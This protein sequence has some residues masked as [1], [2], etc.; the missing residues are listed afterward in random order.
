M[1]TSGIKGTAMADKLVEQK[2]SETAFFAALRRALA[3]MEYGD[4][5]FGS[6]SLAMVFLPV[7][8]RF[9]MK[10]KKARESGNHQLARAF[11]G[12]NE[13]LMA[14]TAF[15]D[16]QFVEALGEETPQIVLLGAGYDSRAY[17]FARLNRGTRVFELDIAPTQNRKIKCLKA[18]RIDIPPQ[19]KF[20]PINFNLEALDG[21]LAK[22]GYRA[23]EK[24]LFTWE[25]VS[26]YLD[27]KSVEATLDFASQAPK[28]S[29]IAFDY[30]IA[31][32]AENMDK[33]YG[34]ETF[35][36]TMQA[37][38]TG[39]QLLFSLEEGEIGLFLE[40]RGLR[41]VE[42][43]NAEEIEKTYLT[44]EDGSLTGRMIGHFRFA[45]AAPMD[46]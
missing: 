16:E 42:H 44:K 3:Y 38:H 41:L 37:Y 32:T 17:R 24:T 20:V 30:T 40:Q 11:P 25:G 7:H 36:R 28:D 23:G 13:Y 26:Y 14:R 6:D 2:P 35:A 18:R 31:L 4:E 9:L 21:V 5:R 33:Y 27:R 39:E 15:F 10:F 46:K 29:R 19:V 34:A 8:Y 1:E 43:L 22:A 45:I 12:M